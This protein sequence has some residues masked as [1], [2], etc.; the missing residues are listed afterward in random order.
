MNRGGLKASGPSRLNMLGMGRW[1]FKKM[2]KL[3]GA[4]QLQEL[5]DACIA[6][7]IKTIPY[8]MSMKVM[9]ISC[10]DLIPEAVGPVGVAVMLK[11]AN[12]SSVQYFI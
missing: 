9:E 10:E 5:R 4:A 11:H 6:L 8:D 12:K 7:D 1:M 2:M 3:H